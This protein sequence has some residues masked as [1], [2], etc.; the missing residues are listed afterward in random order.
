V[1]QDGDLVFRRVLSS[2]L[3]FLTQCSERLH[4]L[5]DAVVKS[6]IF[7]VLARKVGLVAVSLRVGRHWRVTAAATRAQGQTDSHRGSS[8]VTA[9]KYASTES[10]R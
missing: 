1:L 5:R 4:A 7:R 3:E 10:L 8:D 2:L 6:Q 9:D